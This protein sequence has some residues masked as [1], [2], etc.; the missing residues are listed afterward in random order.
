MV[1]FHLSPKINQLTSHRTPRNSV[2]PSTLTG[3]FVEQ[4]HSHYL[5]SNN[6]NCHSL[7][8][9]KLL[10]RCCLSLSRLDNNNFQTR[11]QKY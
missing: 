6:C 11:F 10:T 7:K 8:C 3:I 2:V 4:F 1:T 5:K 9:I